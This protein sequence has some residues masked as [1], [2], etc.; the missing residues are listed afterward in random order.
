MRMWILL[1][2]T[3][4]M[5]PANFAHA[6]VACT[7]P[8]SLGGAYRAFGAANG[9]LFANPAGMSLTTTYS[10]EAAYLSLDGEDETG[11]SVVD[12][13]TSKIGAGLAYTY[14]PVSDAADD[15]ELRYAASAMVVPDVLAVGVM[16]RNLWLGERDQS[17]FALDAGAILTLGRV[18]GLGV[19]IHDLVENEDIG[20]VRR[21]GVGA[22]FTGPLTLALD[23]VTTP[24][25]GDTWGD[26]DYHAGLEF[27]AGG[28]YPFRIGYEALGGGERQYV[29]FGLGALNPKAGIQ[30]GFRQGLDDD[31]DQSFAIA[32]NMF[33]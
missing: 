7:R 25:E 14:V 10:V 16:G 33:L 21:V 4:G 18:F 24:G 5:L 8:L 6:Q 15:H 9:A 19:V 2:L 3:L 1:A 22:A 26:A 31:S 17:G 32:L 28:T 27:L 20:A 12:T 30:V 11:I 13:K 29:T 23:V